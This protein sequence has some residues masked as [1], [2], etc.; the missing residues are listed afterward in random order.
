MSHGARTS[1]SLTSA[2]FDLVAN[3]LGPV[4]T[5]R[6]EAIVAFAEKAQIALIVTTKDREGPSVVNLKPR[7]RATPRS[8]VRHELAL[9]A[10]PLVDALANL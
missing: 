8:I 4:D 1:K 10:S 6:G 3:V 5:L 7:T 2:L 9:M